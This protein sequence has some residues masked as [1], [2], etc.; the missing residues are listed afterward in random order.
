MFR[1]LDPAPPEFV[2]WIVPVV[3]IH[4]MMIAGDV[5]GLWSV[6]WRGVASV[7]PVAYIVCAFANLR[8][9]DES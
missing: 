7:Y 4:I 5:L 9:R 3:W 1:R 2:T 6:N 8:P